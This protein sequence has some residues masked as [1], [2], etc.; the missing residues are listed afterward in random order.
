MNID[1]AMLVVDGN[2]GL[3]VEDVVVFLCSVV[4]AVQR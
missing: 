1:V 4:G 2:T 3:L